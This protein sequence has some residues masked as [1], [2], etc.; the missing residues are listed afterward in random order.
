MSPSGLEYLQH[1]LD[2]AH[3]LTDHSRGLTKDQF[4]GDETLKRAFAR[5]LEIIGEATKKIPSD[6]GTR[7]A[8][9]RLNQ[10]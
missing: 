5:R 8:Q 3:Y 2:E 10:R 6:L 9:M 7:S 1:I 4:L